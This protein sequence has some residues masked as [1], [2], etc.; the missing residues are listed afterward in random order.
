MSHHSTVKRSANRTTY[1]HTPAVD[2]GL[3]VWH[4]RDFVKALDEAGIP[5]N[6]KL[7]AHHNDSTR[8]FSGI[9]V[10]HTEDI[11][12]WADEPAPDTAPAAPSG[13]ESNQ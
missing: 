3:K 9:S 8:H 10:H 11:E 4:L 1:L 7:T 6:A 13:S 5:D 12:G 2:G